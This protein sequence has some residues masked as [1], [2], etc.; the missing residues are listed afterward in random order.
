LPSFGIVACSTDETVELPQQADAHRPASS[1][2]AP[3]NDETIP[4]IVTR[5][6]QDGHG[7]P[8]TGWLKY[9]ELPSGGVVIAQLGTNEYLVTGLH[10][11]VEFA[12]TDPK[13][14]FKPML[15]RVEEGYYKNGNWVFV[16]I[17]NGDQTD[18][19]LNFMSHPQAL[20]VKLA[21]FRVA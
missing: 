14:K 4:A 21:T 3:C 18:W 8:K 7:T 16:R 19:R 11:R 2:E 6:T 13:P 15:A 12:L 20:R 10:A 1:H 9:S 17:W 5:P